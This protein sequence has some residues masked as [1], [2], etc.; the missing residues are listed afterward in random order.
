MDRAV[1]H[2]HLLPWA[3]ALAACNSAGARAALNEPT[4]DTLP[5]GIVR[6]QNTGPTVWPDTSGWRLVEEVVIAPDEGSPGE[7]SDIMSLVADDAGN[8]YVMQDKPVLIKVYGRD[9]QWLRDIGRE[10]DGPGE[11]RGGM[12]TI[13]GDT[14][15]IQDPNNTRMTTFLTD[16]TF[17][18]SHSS[19][20]C[21]WTSTFPVFDGGLVALPGPPPAGYTDGGAWYVTR[22]D[23]TVVDTILMPRQQ[24]NEKGAWTVTRTSGKSRSMMSTG[25]PMQPQDRSIFRSDRNMVRGNTGQYSLVIGATDTDSSRI[26]TAPGTALSLTEAERDSVF[27]D[28]VADVGENWR[29][30]LLEV[31]KKSDI[32]ATR[33]LWS[34]LTIDRLSRIWV[35]RPGPGSDA[36]TLDVFTTDGVLLGTVPSPHRDILNG[37]WT[38]H[39]IHLRDED[40]NGLPI[41]RVFRLDTLGVK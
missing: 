33:P 9:G 19:Q 38:R 41:V 15:V 28:A 14:L 6:V 40:E 4:I 17:I 39:R 30:D 18:T 35:A 10:G 25:I 13:L 37:F 32:P 1:S 20:C 16:G 2:R 5:G 22:L 21:Y 23:G 31:A 11:F 26:F 8:T 3:L 29:E 34:G 27:E 24:G 36:A 7:L 12:F